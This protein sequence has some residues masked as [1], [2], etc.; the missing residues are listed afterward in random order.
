MRVKDCWYVEL[1]EGTVTM[2]LEKKNTAIFSFSGSNIHHPV[3]CAY[4][5]CGDNIRY[6]IFSR[7]YS[8]IYSICKL[9]FFL[10]NSAE[11]CAQ[12]FF[13]K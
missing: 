7:L 8:A 13:H 1:G 6:L 12:E 4:A 10:L 3:L 2:E 5:V 9:I 11:M